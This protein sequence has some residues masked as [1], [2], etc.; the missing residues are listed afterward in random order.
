MKEIAKTLE[1][2]GFHKKSSRHFER[3]DCQFFIEF[4]APPAA[5]GSEPITTP[6]EL[7]SKYGK[8]LL[9]SPT[10]AI[11]D[12]LAAY[13]HWNDF[14]ALDQAVMVAKD[15]NVN[16]SEIERWSIAEGFGEKYQNFLLSCTPRSRK[17]KPD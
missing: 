1:Q 12:R 14:Q 10:D 4:V 9:L 6:F 16:I 3:N 7:T 15:Q 13:Y 17:R 11:K 8:I 2:I 5:V